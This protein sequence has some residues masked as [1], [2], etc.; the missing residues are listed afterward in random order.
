[1]PLRLIYV[2]IFFLANSSL[3]SGCTCTHWARPMEEIKWSDAVFIGTVVAISTDRSK[4]LNRVE[5]Q[6]DR[7]WKGVREPN[8]SVFTSSSG[9]SCGIEYHLFEKW[10]IYAETDQHGLSTH[11]C[12][13]TRPIEDA[14]DDL[15]V[16]GNK[17]VYVASTDKLSTPFWLWIILAAVLSLAIYFVIHLIRSTTK[18]RP[19]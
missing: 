12:S 5:I 11:M 9:S 19:F 14:K 13:R 18:H 7:S 16:L 15:R 1:M 3:A 4:N 17:Y 6:V 8:V 10:L 2:V